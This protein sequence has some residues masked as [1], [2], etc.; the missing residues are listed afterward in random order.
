MKKII[1]NKIKFRKKKKKEA[2]KQASEQASE[3]AS[4]QAKSCQDT[5]RTR[6][7]QRCHT[8]I[9]SWPSTA[10]HAAYS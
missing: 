2:S 9:F 7:L 10:G 1:Q 4:K 5:V 3:Q 6:N 8:F